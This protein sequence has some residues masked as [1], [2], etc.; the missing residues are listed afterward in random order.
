MR[1]LR[2]HLKT[3][4][5]TPQS[6]LGDDLD[7]QML[8]QIHRVLHRPETMSDMS[9]YAKAQIQELAFWRYVAFEGYAGR[10]PRFFPFFQKMLMLNMFAR[11]GWSITELAELSVVEIG[12]GPLGMI[13]I[14]PAARRVAF[15]P[16][17]RHY[18]VLFSKE[19][20]QSIEYTEDFDEL[21]RNGRQSFDLGICFN[22]IDH[23]TNPRELFETYMSL[24]RRGGRFVFQVN[25]VREGLPRPP[26]HEA[27]HP[28]PFTLEK[29]RLW[30]G[31]YASS[32]S[33][34]LVDR[35][36]ANNEFF[37]MAWGYKN[38]K[39]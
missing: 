11:T 27:M 38:R 37:F 33:S 35:P 21:V 4:G 31:E 3:A 17:N 2:Q 26:E 9:A 32:Y 6:Y 20:S 5:D 23:T 29:I 28:S 7:P 8:D 13:E 36:S 14:L 39:R 15:D 12:C 24:I 22:V 34:R 25:T 1:K 30:L 16:L 19:R 10:D 18:S